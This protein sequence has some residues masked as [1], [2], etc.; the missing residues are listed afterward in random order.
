MSVPTRGFADASHHLPVGA[1]PT[2]RK[3]RRRER[4][5]TRHALHLPTVQRLTGHPS[6]TICP[7]MALSVWCMRLSLARV[8]LS[9][10]VATEVV[11]TMRPC[12]PPSSYPSRLSC[13]AAH[14]AWYHRSS[15]CPPSPPIS[16]HVHPTLAPDTVW[17][18]SALPPR[19]GQRP[20]PHPHMDVP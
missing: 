16:Q 14:C 15:P 11:T 18:S 13:H 7:P 8:S 4:R 19:P 12:S 17:S 20:P 6:S 3:L 5:Q 1:S 2:P 10:S 9:E